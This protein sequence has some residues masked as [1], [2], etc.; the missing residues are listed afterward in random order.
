LIL[1]ASTKIDVRGSFGGG[2]Y[3]EEYRHRVTQFQDFQ[4]NSEVDIIVS[5]IAALKPF[6]YPSLLR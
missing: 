5:E 4:W 1:P 2:F 3:M 6:Q